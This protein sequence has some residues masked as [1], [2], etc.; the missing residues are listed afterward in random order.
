M[1]TTTFLHKPFARSAITTWLAGRR[2]NGTLPGIGG[3]P[4]AN[5]TEMILEHVNF[6]CA[7]CRE[8]NVRSAASKREVKMLRKTKSG[9]YTAIGAE[10]GDA[11]VCAECFSL[12]RTVFWHPERLDYVIVGWEEPIQRKR[13]ADVTGEP[14]KRIHLAVDGMAGRVHATVSETLFPNALT[15]IRKLLFNVPQ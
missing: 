2:S 10:V 5:I 13:K 4:A 9:R 14:S 12:N 6:P 3:A 11:V 8:H 1:T 15:A 7:V